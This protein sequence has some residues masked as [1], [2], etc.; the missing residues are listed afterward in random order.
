MLLFQFPA[1][2]RKVRFQ[3]WEF[4]IL[5]FLCQMWLLSFNW[6]ISFLCVA[7]EWVRPVMKRDKQVLLHWGYF[8]DRCWVYWD[9]NTLLRTSVLSYCRSQGAIPAIDHLK[10]LRRLYLCFFISLDLWLCFFCFLVMTPGSQPVRLKLLWRILP[11][12]KSPERYYR[13]CQIHLLQVVSFFHLDFCPFL[14]LLEH[15]R[16]F[17]HSAFSFNLKE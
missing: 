6:N 12:R 8:P 17:F 15:L 2:W 4:T 1:V 10:D 3:R 9:T 7:E 11:V 14:I 16:F 5:C 13:S